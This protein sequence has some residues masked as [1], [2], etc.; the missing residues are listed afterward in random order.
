M[1]RY[2]AHRDSDSNTTHIVLDTVTGR[3]VR[4]PQADAPSCGTTLRMRPG[5]RT[6]ATTSG[7]TTRLWPCS[8]NLS[9]PRHYRRGLH[10]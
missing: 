1:T 8:I 2:Q 9:S 10:P 3:A 4:D 6:S 7:L 5:T